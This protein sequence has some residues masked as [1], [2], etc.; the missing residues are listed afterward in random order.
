MLWLVV[1][2]NIVF[3]ISVVFSEHKT[4]QE[5]IAWILV[6]TFLPVLGALIYIFFGNPLPF[7]RKQNCKNL[8]IPPFIDYLLINKKDILGEKNETVAKNRNLIL[9]N[10]I[11][12]LSIFSKDNTLYLFTDAKE[13]YENL[14]LDILNAKHSINIEYFIIRNDNVGKDFINLLSKKAKEGVIVNLLYDELGSLKTTMKMFKSLIDAG[15]NVHRFFN[16]IGINLLRVNHRNHRKI[17]VIDGKIGYIGGMNIGLEYMGLKELTPWRDTHLKIEGSAV[18]S[19]QAQFLGDLISSK[20]DHNLFKY[21]EY[22]PEINFPGNKCMQII[23]SGPE[24]GKENIKLSFIKMINLA[25]KSIYIQTPYFVPDETLKTGLK[26]AA[27]SGVDV[28]IMIP[29]KP[30]KKYVYYITLSHIEE[31]LKCGVKFY[32]HSGFLHSKTIVTDCEITSIG[33]TNFDIRSFSLNYEVNAFIYDK[34]F[35]AKNV[36][37]FLE[38]IKNCKPLTMEEFKK[39]GILRKISEKILKLFSPLA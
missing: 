8:S 27:L 13:K 37:T 3:I 15:G 24:S 6:L 38:D 39:R 12:S 22:F 35:A 14:F 36:N 21:S 9:F 2:I 29:G 34:E 5:A 17:V 4:P 32:I 33:T 28:R 11:N 19:L 1:I 31:L 7:S 23:T 20:C 25:K 16:S 30:D 18:Y 10:S 26:I